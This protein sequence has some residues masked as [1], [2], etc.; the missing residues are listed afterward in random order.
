MPLNKKYRALRLVLGDQLNSEH[1][2]YKEKSEDILYVIMELQQEATYTRHHVQKLVAFFLSME[3]FANELQE[4]GNHVLHISLELSE[5]SGSLIDNLLKLIQQFEIEQFEY[6]LPDEYRL[7]QQ[8][9]EFCEK[10]TIPSCTYDSEHFLTERME[11]NEFFKNKKSYLMESF[12]RNMRKRYQLMMDPMDSNKPLT[13]KWN[14]DKE[15]RGSIKKDHIVIPPKLFN[16]SIE[17]VLARINKYNIPYIGTINEKDFIWPTSRKES[18]E[19]LEF[20]LEECF[21]YFGKYQDA[22]VQRSWSVYHARISFSMNVKM[23]SPLEVVKKAIKKW[24]N[25]DLIDIAQCEGFVRQIIGWREYMRGVYWAH[26]PEYKSLNYFGHENK[27]PDYFWTGDTKMGCVRHA[28]KQSLDFAYAHHIQRLMVTGN[29]ALLAGINPDELD[30][31]YLGIYIDA[32]EWVEITNTRGMSQFADGGIVGTKPYVSSANYINKM[33]D[34]CNGCYYNK[35][36]KYGEKACPFNSL[37]WHFYEI[38]RELLGN[39]HRISMMYRVWDKN[40]DSEK[41]AILDQASYYLDNLET[42]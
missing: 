24:E 32:I 25:S 27:L 4:R 17:P 1:S 11:L 9:I 7:D 2:W 29:F 35:K 14:Y 15:N 23:I 26:M 22:M 33:S 37:Y 20:F 8:L 19:L 21:P 34:Y 39:N 41:Q 36:L 13:G 16:K 5:Y 18:L 42:L 38:N 10:L 3:S 40:I 6:Q 31:W 28:V 30:E 12:Y